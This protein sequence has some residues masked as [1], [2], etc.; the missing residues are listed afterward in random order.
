[1]SHPTDIRRS[2][3]LTNGSHWEG[4]EDAPENPLGLEVMDVAVQRRILTAAMS[5]TVERPVFCCSDHLAA[6][7]VPSEGG[8]DIISPS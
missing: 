3:V 1:M 4:Q 6:T 2:V 7:S 5:L 8:E